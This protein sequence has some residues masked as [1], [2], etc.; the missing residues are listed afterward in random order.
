MVQFGGV[1]TRARI[2][3]PTSE[4]KDSRGFASALCIALNRRLGWCQEGIEPFLYDG[5]ALAGGLL[6][7]GSVENLNLS[8]TITD[9]AGGLHRLCCE[10]HGLAIGAQHMRQEL[11]R[12]L[13][14]FSFGTIVHH[15]E[16]SAHSLLRRMH[17]V[18][19][20]SLLNLR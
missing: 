19:G 5:V 6:E 17:G 16:P 12:V 11:V 3:G 4:L 13:Q 1:G 18:A 14:G 15:E 2:P 8:S 7:A 10:R 20:D 9:Q